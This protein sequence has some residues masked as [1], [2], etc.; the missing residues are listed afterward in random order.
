[1]LHVINKFV[2]VKVTDAVQKGG[3][4]FHSHGEVARVI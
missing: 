3:L 1:M 2:T 4:D